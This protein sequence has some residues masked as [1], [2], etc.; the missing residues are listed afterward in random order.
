MLCTNM[1]AKNKLG[2]VKTL[3]YLTTHLNTGSHIAFESA[4]RVAME[5]M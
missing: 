3:E 5:P 1:L 2:F 4:S